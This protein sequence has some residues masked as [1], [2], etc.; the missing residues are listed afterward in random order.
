MI[1]FGNIKLIKRRGILQGPIKLNREKTNSLFGNG[2]PGNI[3]Q[4]ASDGIQNDLEYLRFI[5]RGSK[6]RTVIKGE[7]SINHGR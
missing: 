7:V 2:I 1:I 4:I 3:I 5:I 6:F